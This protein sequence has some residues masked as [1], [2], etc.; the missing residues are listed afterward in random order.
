M[1]TLRQD[2]LDALRQLR[3]SPVFTL[4]AALT[5]ALGIGVTTAI[6]SLVDS[7]MLKSLPVA[8][9]SRL[10][11]VGDGVNCC[12]VIGPQREWGI[13]R[14]GGKPRS[15]PSCGNHQSGTGAASRVTGFR[16]VTA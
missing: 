2:F 6:F 1:R 13:L 11:R 10:Y 12:G 8:D 16:V 5:L 15:G 9:P 14:A 7:V 3:L 4:T